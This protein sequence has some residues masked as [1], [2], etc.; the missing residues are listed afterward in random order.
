[1]KSQP[2]G[3][4]F[5]D[6][7][8]NPVDQFQEAPR[9]ERDQHADDRGEDEQDAV[10][11]APDQRAR[12]GRAA[13]AASLIRRCLRPGR[14]RPAGVR[15]LRSPASG[16]ASPRTRPFPDRARGAGCC[17]RSRWWLQPC[18][19]SLRPGVRR[20]RV[21][22]SAS[23]S[24]SR[25]SACSSSNPTGSRDPPG[26]TQHATPAAPA[27]GHPSPAPP[28]PRDSAA[29]PSWAAPHPGPAPAHQTRLPRHHQPSP[30]WHLLHAPAARYRSRYAPR[31]DTFCR[32]CPGNTTTRTLVS[33]QPGEPPPRHQ[34]AS[35]DALNCVSRGVDM[36]D[37]AHQELPPAKRRRL[38]IGQCC[39]ACWS[40][41]CW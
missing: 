39:A 1:M 19:P 30:P 28:G 2:A 4:A 35:L 12:I 20:S 38:I 25:V 27:P 14:R 5:V 3:Q 11:L 17:L 36:T 29:R 8:L 7:V 34:A 16:L 6:L 26:L 31:L 21:V 24:A 41:R 23:D 37:Q 9:G 33:P 32:C 10:A 18:R 40:R 13:A 22:W 15:A